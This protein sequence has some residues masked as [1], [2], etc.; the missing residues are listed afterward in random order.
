MARPGQEKL[1]SLPQHLADRSIVFAKSFGDIRTGFLST[2]RVPLPDQADHLPAH[3]HELQR[4][5]CAVQVAVELIQDRPSISS[6]LALRP[7]ILNF[8]DF[9]VHDLLEQN[10]NIES[11][12]RFRRG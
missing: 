2:E 10:K 9:V 4:C 6:I 7:L 12:Y 3:I 8:V 11:S 1:G 5:F